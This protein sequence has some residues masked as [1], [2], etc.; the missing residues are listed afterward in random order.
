M[1]LSVIVMAA[2]LAGA[3]PPAATAPA[4]VA[5]VTAP[6]PKPA[7]PKLVCVEEAQMGSLFKQ[8][9]CATAEEWEKRRE[10]DREAM[11]RGGGRSSSCTTEAC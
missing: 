6:A 5:P 1:G 10:R 11:S 9:T 2:A 3:E 4:T 8:K 7:K